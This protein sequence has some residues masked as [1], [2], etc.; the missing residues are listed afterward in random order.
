MKFYNCVLLIICTVGDEYNVLL[1]ELKLNLENKLNVN[2][3]C[4][5]N[6]INLI[7][8][9]TKSLAIKG[10][11]KMFQWINWVLWKLLFNYI[12]TL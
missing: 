5:Q 12:I 10:H 1:D 9:I 8:W 4:K 7:S 2:D 11:S 3:L 6:V